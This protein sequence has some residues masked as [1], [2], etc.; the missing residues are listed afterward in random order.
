[1]TFGTLIR[2]QP[3]KEKDPLF[4]SMREIETYRSLAS[5]VI[6]Q[7]IA[8]LK[9]SD[10]TA[11][12]SAMTFIFSETRKDL[13]EMWLGWLG[14]TEDQF[15]TLLRRKS[16]RGAEN[17]MDSLELLIQC[18]QMEGIEF[19]ESLEDMTKEW[20]ILSAP[21]AEELHNAVTETEEDLVDSPAV[22]E[23]VH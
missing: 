12:L 8:D 22:F 23:L 1:M 13:R 6:I 20:E 14:Y 18:A 21:I 9:S 10:P 15:Y 2:T 7:A 5:Q 11:R 3:N 16:L 19:H 4:M 17:T